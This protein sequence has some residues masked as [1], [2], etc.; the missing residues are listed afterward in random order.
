MAVLAMEQTCFIQ[1]FV[2]SVP[3]KM[4]FSSSATAKIQFQM[5]KDDDQE[6]QSLSFDDA[7]AA[8]V[9]EDEKAR[10][11]RSGNALSEE[12][13]AEFES[14]KTEYEAMRDKIRARASTLN[15]EKSVT[16]QK[17]IE[18]AS[19]KAMAREEPQEL[20]LSKFGMGT[21]GE[22]PEDELTEEQK[23]SIDEAGQMD[24]IGQ[25]MEEFKNA[26]FP[27][28]GAT[29]RQTAFML[30]IFAFTSTYILFLDGTLRE[31]FTDVL[32][33]IPGPDSVFDYSDLELPP[34]WSENMD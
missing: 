12:R 1:A 34:G 2:P 27:G 30:V 22:D 18:E 28:V 29:L 23:K 17:A 5:A 10:A 20:D 32:K 33:I 26:K 11:E 15:I 24:L 9:D 13:N 3:S 19:R 25:A 31:F 16:T 14:K 6:S 8:I 21:I 7:G 4:A